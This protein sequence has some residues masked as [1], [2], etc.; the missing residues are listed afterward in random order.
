MKDYSHIKPTLRS[1]AVDSK[2]I[3]S[4][5]KYATEVVIPALAK[6]IKETQD[7]DNA[8]FMKTNKIVHTPFPLHSEVMIKNVNKENKTDPHYEGPFY[9]SGM[10]TNGSYIHVHPATMVQTASVPT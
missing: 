4:R 1:D 6:R 3:E 7:V 10:T 9:I 2:A 5:L 8:Y